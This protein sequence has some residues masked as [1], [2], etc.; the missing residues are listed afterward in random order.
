M[1][2][3]RGPPGVLA[4]RITAGHSGWDQPLQHARQPSSGCGGSRIC[5][6]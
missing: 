4:H 3:S 5:A 2:A 6:L 1:R